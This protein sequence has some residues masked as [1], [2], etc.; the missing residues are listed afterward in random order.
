MDYQM[1]SKLVSKTRTITKLGITMYK[2]ACLYE[3]LIKK[4]YIQGILQEIA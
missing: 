4:G 3:L 2:N 1:N